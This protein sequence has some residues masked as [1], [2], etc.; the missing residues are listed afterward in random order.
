MNEKRI[1]AALVDNV[2]PLLADG[3]ITTRIHASLPFEEVRAAHEMLDANE[4]IGKVVLVMR[5]DQAAAVPS[6]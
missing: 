4:Q 3:R 5:P 2:W 6:A 1:A